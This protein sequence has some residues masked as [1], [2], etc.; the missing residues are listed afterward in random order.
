[1]DEI[2]NYLNTLQPVNKENE[3]EIEPED[4]QIVP[5]ENIEETQDKDD[6]LNDGIKRLVYSGRNG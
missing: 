6:G 2:E 3:N 4:N 5:D 1:M